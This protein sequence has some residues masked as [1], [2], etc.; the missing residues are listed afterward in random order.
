MA[1]ESDPKRDRVHEAIQA[2]RS[3]EDGLL[4]GWV[5]VA[6]WMDE[7]GERW[8]SKTHATGTA[9]WAAKGMMHEALFGDWPE[10]PDAS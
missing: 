2:V 8:L 1:D 3:V 4:T 10:Q 6:E 9:S 5:V 7:S